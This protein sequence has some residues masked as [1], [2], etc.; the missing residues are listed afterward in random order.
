[1]NGGG[2]EGRGGREGEEGMEEEMAGVTKA[3][4]GKLKDGT[5]VDIYTLTNKNGLMARIITII[6]LVAD[7]H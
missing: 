2:R 4:F 5:A 3:S 7:Q 6:F 1:M